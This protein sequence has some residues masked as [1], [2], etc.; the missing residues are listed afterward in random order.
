[1][2]QAF[3][4]ESEVVSVASLTLFQ[5]VE[6]EPERGRRKSKKKSSP[7]P[8][9]AP[10]PATTTATA[11]TITAQASPAPSG[12]IGDRPKTLFIIDERPPSA[13]D[14]RVRAGYGSLPVAD[15][16]TIPFES[17]KVSHPDIYE[18]YKRGPADNHIP[19][20]AELARE[21]DLAFRTM[22]ADAMRRAGAEAE[23]RRVLD[24]AA[25][26]LVV[27]AADVEPELEEPG[28]PDPTPG[29]PPGGDLM[30]ARR[31]RRAAA[32]WL[33]LGRARAI[34]A[35]ALRGAEESATRLA[36]L[37]VI[38][39]PDGRGNLYDPETGEVLSGPSSM[40]HRVE[41]GIQS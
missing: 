14:L 34:V 1:M 39:V 10:A 21:V 25:P 36:Q 35:E 17:L 18:R 11:T 22:I 23:A 31:L 37:L 15:S 38:A 27:G 9:R 12:R 26:Q 32:R 40:T 4:V 7:A 33:R 29:A 19:M 16:R 6:P 20:P 2:G 24:P 5:D 3:L 13:W 8:P 28:A 41:D 30:A